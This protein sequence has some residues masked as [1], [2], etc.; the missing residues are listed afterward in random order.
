VGGQQRIP[1]SGIKQLVD[2][3]VK[4]V[5]E[6]IPSDLGQYRT[7]QRVQ[8]EVLDSDGIRSADR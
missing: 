1:A 2:A 6:A 3:A 7:R 8:P 4:A 5:P